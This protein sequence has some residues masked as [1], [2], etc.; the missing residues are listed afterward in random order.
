MIYDLT[1]LYSLARERLVEA[2]AWELH[3]GLQAAANGKSIE[4]CRRLASYKLKAPCYRCGTSGRADPNCSESDL[5]GRSD[6]L[7]CDGAGFI[8][9]PHLDWIKDGSVQFRLL[10]PDH[11]DY[12]P[13]KE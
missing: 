3:G 9:L 6:C 2:E 5:E 13:T 11:P 10:P 12:D 8:A 4:E 7:D 1:E